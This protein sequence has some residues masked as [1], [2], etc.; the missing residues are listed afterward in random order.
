ME[1][2]Q[3]VEPVTRE[4]CRWVRVKKEVKVPRQVVR[5]VTVDAIKNTP[6]TVTRRVPIDEFGNVL[7]IP[8][9]SEVTSP[10]GAVERA[11][12]KP[13]LAD[14]QPK[15]R[16]VLVPETIAGPEA[17]DLAPIEVSGVMTLEEPVAP[18]TETPLVDENDQ[19]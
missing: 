18:E 14:E 2:V 16:T 8:D 15:Q 19:R 17:K 13:T 10:S 3:R 7:A 11:T 6:R 9:D 5:Y 1:T 4:V 12:Q